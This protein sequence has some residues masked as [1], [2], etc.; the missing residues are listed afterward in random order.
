MRA[1]MA[2][3]RSV[4][5][6]THSASTKSSD[7]SLSIV[8]SVAI[9]SCELGMRRAWSNAVCSSCMIARLRM[10]SRKRSLPTNP[11]LICMIASRLSRKRTMSYARGLPRL[12]RMR[13]I[14]STITR[15]R[16]RRRKRR[17]RDARRSSGTRSPQP[18]S[19]STRS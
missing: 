3:V 5:N 16:W 1:Q 10:V 19:S 14:S 11:R 8:W 15:C 18:R 7:R 2:S 17:I 12:S 9:N 6:S 4:K 13:R